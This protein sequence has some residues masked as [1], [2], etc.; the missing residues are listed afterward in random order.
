MRVRKN[1]KDLTDLEVAD[2]NQALVKIKENGKYDEQVTKF[3]GDPHRCCNHYL[4]RV[5][6]RLPSACFSEAFCIICQQ[7]LY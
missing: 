4:T 1:I 7:G 2:L 6:P 5:N 3:H